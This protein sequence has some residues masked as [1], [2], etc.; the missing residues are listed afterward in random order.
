MY[1]IVTII[2]SI[3]MYPLGHIKRY[4]LGHMRADNSQSM[5]E[6]YIYLSECRDDTHVHIQ[7]NAQDKVVTPYGVLMVA[8]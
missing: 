2:K 8:K 7:L 6:G 1:H 5:W 4:N 3:N